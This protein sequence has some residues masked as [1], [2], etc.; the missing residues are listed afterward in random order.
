MSFEREK[1]LEALAFFDANVRNGGWIKLLKLVYYLDLV[2]FRKTGRTVTGLRYEAWPMGPVPPSLHAELKTPSAD[3]HKHF[4]VTQSSFDSR[5]AAFVPTIDTDER[6][7]EQAGALAPSRLPGSIKPKKPFNHLYLS[8][9]E[10]D[11]AKR[12]AEVFKNANAAQ[13]SEA[14]HNKKGPWEKALK[15]VA[16]NSKAPTINLL[17]GDIGLGKA[18]EF[19]T[20][21]E[22]AEYLAARL[23]A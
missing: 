7:L 3:I 4:T 16:P 22:I 13:M 17:D 20:P 14:S 15:S 5:S 8:R 23:Q 18:D 11:T 19:M 9:S 1:L 6:E 10:L 12:L 2:Q 21:D